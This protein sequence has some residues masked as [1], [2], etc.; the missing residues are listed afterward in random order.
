MK[1]NMSMKTNKVLMA[2]GI[3]LLS[4][5]ATLGAVFASRNAIKVSRTAA[6]AKSITFDEAHYN[7]FLGTNH[8]GEFYVY[9][10]DSDP[11][12][13]WCGTYCDGWKDAY[14]GN[15]S[16]GFFIRTLGS[17]TP[18]STT[19]TFEL[20]FRLGLNNITSFSFTFGNLSAETSISLDVGVYSWN[21][22]GHYHD[23]VERNEYAN[24]LT[25]IDSATFSFDV[26]SKNYGSKIDMFEVE[27]MLNGFENITGLEGCYISS[28]TANW[29]C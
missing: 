27:V 16:D 28:I 9:P 18:T 24:Q 19:D 2:S 29:S 23:C 5:G 26:A 20:R 25:G 21:E 22:T 7:P 12:E 13:F 3:A 10:E 1:G 8:Y 6:T 15:G 14:F 11:V 4:I 17:A